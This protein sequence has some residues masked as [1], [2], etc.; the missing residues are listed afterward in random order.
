MAPGPP[1]LPSG[2]PPLL[3]LSVTPRE[4]VPSV[5]PVAAAGADG[6]SVVKTLRC[7]IIC[8]VAV[9][10][11][12]CQYE[13]IKMCPPSLA[14]L[15]IFHHLLHG[16]TRQWHH[17]KAAQKKPT[18]AS[19][20]S[21]KHARHDFSPAVLNLLCFRKH[22]QSHLSPDEAQV[23]HR[24]VRHC[25]YAKLWRVRQPNES[26]L[27]FTGGGMSD[28]CAVITGQTNICS[29]TGFYRISFTWGEPCSDEPGRCDA[30]EGDAEAPSACPP[31]SMLATRM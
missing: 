26:P 2:P 19:S 24:R 23:A 6:R 10:R 28:G 15:R 4:R 3:L 16:S 12:I 31:V 29:L 9:A 1:L 14:T 22:L 18:V 13:F 7:I 30:R 8:R 20:K 21:D 11:H 17:G 25:L 5:G 27:L